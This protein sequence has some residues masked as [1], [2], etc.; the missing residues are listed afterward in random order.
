MSN[1]HSV[2]DAFQLLSLNSSYG[3]GGSLNRSSDLSAD[4][5]YP[6]VYDLNG[7]CVAHGANPSNVGKTLW[8]IGALHGV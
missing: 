3:G 6:F 2:E 8:E 4:W 1:R 7:T 5:L